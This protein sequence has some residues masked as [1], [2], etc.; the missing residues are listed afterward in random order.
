M[1]YEE[2]T[3]IPNEQFD[4]IISY[5]DEI[6]EKQETINEVIYNYHTE[7]DLRLIRTK[8]YAKLSFKTNNKH[9]VVYISKKYEKELNEM[10]FNI[11]IAIDFKRFRNRHKYL[12]NNLYITIDKN[13][14]TGNI[15]RVKFNYKNE[16]EKEKLIELKNKLYEEANIE[17]T[18]LD[19]FEEIY[20]K[21]RSSW[22]DLVGDMDEEEFLN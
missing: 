4:N 21:Y 2:K 14:K 22:N 18:P 13:I 8:E 5:F 3:V 10:F 11:G 12:Y 19:K 15:L 16:E 6:S 1:V 17:K 9:N 20:G 7:G